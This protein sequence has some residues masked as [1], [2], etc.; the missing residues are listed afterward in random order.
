MDYLQDNFGLS[1]GNA[2][3]I[4][5]PETEQEAVAYFKETAEKTPVTMSK[6]GTG[7]VRRENF[8]LR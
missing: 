3:E 7:I 6:P 8:L 4:I 1:A 2:D 5:F